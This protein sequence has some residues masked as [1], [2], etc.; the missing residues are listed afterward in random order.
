MK[1]MR[2]VFSLLLVLL[3]FIPS[4]KSQ[5]FLEKPLAKIGNLSITKDEFLQRYEF[6][7]LFGKN[8]KGMRES[9][10]LEFLY[11]LVA[12]KLWALEAENQKLDTMEVMKFAGEEYEKMFVRDVLFRKEIKSKIKVT[13]KEIIEGFIKKNTTL[14][15]NYLISEDKVE[16]YK[17]YNLLEQGIPFDTILVY[18]PEK[19]EQKKPIEVV[20]GQMELSIE[21]SLY[22]LKVDQYT[23][24]IF[25]PDGWYIF[26]L[27]NK[28][29]AI[30]N[31]INERENARKSG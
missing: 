21:D 19:A 9:L 6:T 15:V 2:A 26:K 12:E 17:L 16:I 4:I 18:S 20:Y 27:S 7:P 28:T 24:P 13:E 31:T 29:Q 22:N 25:T 1:E 5:S 30:L 23:Q 14:S 8:R 11:S 3:I 10:K